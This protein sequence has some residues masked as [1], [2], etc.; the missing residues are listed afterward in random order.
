MHGG[1]THVKEHLVGVTGDVAKCKEVPKQIRKE[2]K[3]H[4]FDK[5]KIMQEAK[6]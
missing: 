6:F 3:A 2:M 4:I 1:V 5:I